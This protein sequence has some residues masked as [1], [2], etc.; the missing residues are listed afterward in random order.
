MLL[1]LRPFYRFS[2]KISSNYPYLE[3]TTAF[4]EVKYAIVQLAV[5]LHSLSNQTWD[6]L[7][8]V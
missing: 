5:C 4:L 2:C 3:G 6:E 7:V 8:T 1:T